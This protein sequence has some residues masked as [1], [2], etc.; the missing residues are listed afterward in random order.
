MRKLLRIA[1]CLAVPAAIVTGPASAA[2]HLCGHDY[3]DP[4]C[5]GVDSLHCM[6]YDLDGEVYGDCQPDGIP[7]DFWTFYD[8]DFDGVAEPGNPRDIVMQQPDGNTDGTSESPL[9]DRRSRDLFQLA[10]SF[11][12]DVDD[13]SRFLIGAPSGVEGDILRGRVS[14]LRLAL[15]T[16]VGGSVE[17]QIALGP[18]ICLAEDVPSGWIVD[19][20]VPPAGEAYFYVG[21]WPSQG[22]VAPE[23]PIPYGFSRCL[24]RV[25]GPLGA[26]CVP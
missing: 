17:M 12:F 10:D 21:R 20:Q 14:Q 7:D 11:L 25:P 26:D 2:D 4:N 24:P 18:T 3:L 8:G 5:D 9:C 6:S 23:I 15:A 19:P 13:P 16:G 22:S 1:A